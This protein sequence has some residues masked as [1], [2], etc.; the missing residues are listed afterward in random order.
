[1]ADSIPAVKKNWKG[2]SLIIEV[3]YITCEGVKMNPASRKLMDAFE[4]VKRRT[5]KRQRQIVPRENSVCNPIRAIFDCPMARIMAGYPKGRLD[6]VSS[7]KGSPSMFVLNPCP[8]AAF[9][10][11]RR[12]SA[13]S[14]VSFAPMTVLYEKAPTWRIIK[15]LARISVSLLFSRRLKNLIKCAFLWEFAIACY[16]WAIYIIWGSVTRKMSLI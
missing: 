2:I 15:I 12:Y 14:A 13:E 9:C 5:K 16:H 8:L 4:P 6:T 11:H 3:A 10:A 1:M 7:L